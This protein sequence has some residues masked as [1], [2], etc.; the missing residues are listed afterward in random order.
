MNGWFITGG[1]N[2]MVFMNVISGGCIKFNYL[3]LLFKFYLNEKFA[4]PHSCLRVPERISGRPRPA[5]HAASP[6]L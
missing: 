2:C 5:M 1:G 6:L 4:A 3:V